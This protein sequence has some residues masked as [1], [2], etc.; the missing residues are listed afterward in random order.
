M[1]FHPYRSEIRVRTP[2]NQ[3]RSSTLTTNLI[4]LMGS[5]SFHLPPIHICHLLRLSYSSLFPITMSMA[6]IHKL[7]RTLQRKDI[8]V[9]YPMVMVIKLAASASTCTVHR[10]AAIPLVLVASSLSRD[11]TLTLLAMKSSL[12]LRQLLFRPVLLLRT[13]SSV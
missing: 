1:T 4:S 2:S 9:K 10:W 8:L 3:S 12:P 7:A 11:I 13:A 5:S 6:P